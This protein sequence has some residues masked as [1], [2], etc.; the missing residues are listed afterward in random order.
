[1][2]LTARERRI[3][4]KGSKVRLV[5][6]WAGD[7][8]KYLIGSTGTVLR[9]G[10]IEDGI[11]TFLVQFPERRQALTC[12]KD[13]LRVVSVNKKIDAEI[14]KL[15]RQQANK[16]MPLIGP[17]LDAW[18]GI[19][20]DTKSEPDLKHFASQIHRLYQAMEGD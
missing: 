7:L 13:E 3:I 17:L 18:E 8:P 14:E 5:K 15:R 11:Q 19:S 10:D 16:V 6:D 12:W 4:R 9:R 1:M 2:K 20:N